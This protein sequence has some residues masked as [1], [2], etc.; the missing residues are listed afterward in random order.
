MFLD[1]SQISNS[2]TAITTTVSPYSASKKIK[3][4][5]KKNSDPPSI[6]IDLDSDISTDIDIDWMIVDPNQLAKIDSLQKEVDMLDHVHQLR[7]ALRTTHANYELALEILQKLYDLNI[8]ALMLI[9]NRDVIDTIVK[10][11]KY[12]GNAREWNVSE[13]EVFQHEQKAC[14]I[15]R[16][17]RSVFYMF[18]T[19]F[20]IPNGKTFQE[21][22][23]KEVNKFLAKT[24][25]K[26][27]FQII[28]E[29][30][31]V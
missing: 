2:E 21:V 19:L 7:S 3:L 20:T 4:C 14:Q 25:D 9:K 8:D 23:I 16:K 5:N 27:C 28:N 31:T 26:S 22:Y 24:K 13:E 12:I 10:V 17:A 15:R 29:S 18:K 11:A 6:N 1:T 30:T